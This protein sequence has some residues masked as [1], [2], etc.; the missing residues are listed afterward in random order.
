MQ[1][2]A[3]C[4]SA[5]SRQGT[6]RRGAMP[7]LGHKRSSHYGRIVAAGEVRLDDGRRLSAQ[8]LPGGDR[9]LP[10]RGSRQLRLYHRRGRG[11][12]RHPLER[13]PDDPQSPGSRRD[14]RRDGAHRRSQADRLRAGGERHGDAR[15][16]LEPDPRPPASL[17]RGHRLHPAHHPDAL[18]PSSAADAPRR[19]IRWAR[20]T[21]RRIIWCGRSHLAMPELTGCR[22]QA[23][24]GERAARGARQ[25][26][27]SAPLPAAR[28]AVRSAPGRFRGA[29]AMGEPALGAHAARGLHS[30]CRGDGADRSDVPMGPR[31]RRR[32]P[33]AI[34]GGIADGRRP[35]TAGLP[36]R[37][38]SRSIRSTTARRCRSST[39][40]RANTA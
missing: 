5:A 39:A 29:H 4:C 34:P 23:G 21:P 8:G 2:Q 36:W 33:G 26:R 27:A 37:S 11:R 3:L 38:M 6:G 9:D 25:G 19:G 10:E 30:A 7:A 18:P 13:P 17:R 31:C 40:S 32:V 12:D 35:A 20:P 24:A 14:V 16:H 22:R 1:S 15:H 28:R